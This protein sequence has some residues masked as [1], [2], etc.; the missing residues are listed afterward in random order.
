MVFQPATGELDDSFLQETGLSVKCV[1]D[2]IPRT[3][4]SLLL[5]RI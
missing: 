5:T 2:A 1:L 3:I 4:N